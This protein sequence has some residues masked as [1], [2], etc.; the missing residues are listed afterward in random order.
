MCGK[1]IDGKKNGI[2]NKLYRRV[3][4]NSSEKIYNRTQWER[5]EKKEERERKIIIR[6]EK[7]V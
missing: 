2:K 6:R 3:S 7:F 4:N 5:K 1:W